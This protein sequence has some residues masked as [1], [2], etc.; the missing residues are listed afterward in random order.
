M[1][2]YACTLHQIV[3]LHNNLNINFQMYARDWFNFIN[4]KHLGLYSSD[5]W[6]LGVIV[7]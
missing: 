6:R 7:G 3:D 5:T 4:G 1:P 2:N